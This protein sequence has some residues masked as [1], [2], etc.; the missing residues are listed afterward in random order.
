MAW[1]LR[2]TPATLALLPRGGRGQVLVCQQIRS[3][4]ERGYEK[5]EGI[6][7]EKSASV[8]LGPESTWPENALFAEVPLTQPDAMRLGTTIRYI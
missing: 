3:R 5:Y 6:G 1:L 4:L 7:K 8:E 2:P